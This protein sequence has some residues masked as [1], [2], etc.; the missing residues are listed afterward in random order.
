M[1]AVTVGWPAFNGGEVGEEFLARADVDVYPTTCATMENIFPLIQGPMIKAPGTEY[2]ETLAGPG[3]LLP[4]VFNI[5]QTI[6]L[7]FSASKIQFIFDG[8]LILSA[9]GPATIGNFTDSSDVGASVTTGATSSILTATASAD[10][11]A[12]S[13]ITTASPL[14]ACS[15]QFTVGTRPIK[16]RIGTSAGA[17][18]I[19][20]ET[21]FAP[22]THVQTFTPGVSPYYLQ[23]TLEDEGRSS[24]TAISALA[25]GPLSVSAPYQAADFR[26]LRH[27]QSA[28]TFWIYHD[29]YRTRVLERRSNTSWS[30]RL[31]RPTDGPFMIENDTTV[32]LTPSN[33]T[34]SATVTASAATFT[35]N[36]VGRILELVY[37]GQR[38]DAT[39]SA[40]NQTSS[41]VRITGTG[42]NRNFHYIVASGLTGTVVLQ[43]SVG[44]EID[45]VD[46]ETVTTFGSDVSISDGLDNQIIYYRLKVTAYTSGSA[47]ITIFYSLGETI[48]NGEI[49]AYTSTTQVTVEIAKGFGGDG[50]GTTRWSLGA[51]SDGEGWPTAGTLWDGRHCI[52]RDDRLWISAS[53]DYESFAVGTDDADAISRRMGTG[54][55]NIARWIEGGSRLLIGAAGAEL[56][57]R[58]NASD[59]PITPTNINL[60]TASGRGSAAVQALAVGDRRVAY[61]SRS[62]RRL[63]QMLYDIE[64][65]AHRSD[66]M[67][68]L[69]KDIAGADDGQ[70]IQLAWQ[71]E[72]ESRIWCLRDDGQIAVMLYAPDEGVYG[73]SRL[74][75]AG[76][77]ATYTSVCILPGTP[78]DTA[79]VIVQRTVNGAAVY[80]LERFKPERVTTSADAWRVHAGLQ[81]S[82]AA[83]TTLTG[84]DH[85]EGESVAIWANGRV[86]PSRTVTS[87]A[88]TLDYAVTKAIAGLNY[89]GLWKSAKLAYGS[90]LGS[91]LSAEKQVKRLG[92]IVRDTAVGALSY[93]RDFTNTDI[94][95]TEFEDGYLM[96]TAV[97]LASLEV[98]QMFDGETDTDS[99]VCLV[100]DKPAPVMVL[101]L[102][103][104]MDLQERT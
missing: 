84:L 78:E 81:Y 98:N 55:V 20:A 71:Q 69:H 30:L 8:A 63:C 18:D 73:W 104:H 85:L 90:R 44:N 62:G 23:A 14:V 79:Y 67:T 61:V 42:A 13:T 95:G 59:E 49:S 25:A 94:V 27:E 65:N 86:H 39:F 32:T 12:R 29:E 58:S 100:M 80:H 47:A 2:V 6:G 82:G 17:A 83:A 93:G 54:A 52:V 40:L 38:V 46:Y 64:S 101:A 68:R 87:G 48:G 88:V 51:W 11:K 24:I 28:D 19:V 26:R 33:R 75:A 74:K 92:A 9:G 34:G 35:A 22:G 77:D 3:W 56:E 1:G 15:L 96:D 41:S 70:F 97:P 7:L 66:D 37:T 76:V 99:R 91:A 10:A 45:W 31:F 103:P 102:I 36:D 50:S 60:R 16:V 43:R 72:P 89:S 57:V 5:D 21:T 53:D 4:F